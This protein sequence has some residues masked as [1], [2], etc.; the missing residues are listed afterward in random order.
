MSF[1]YGSSRWHFGQRKVS[2][3]IPSKLEAS[4]NMCQRGRS[5]QVGSGTRRSS[6]P[7][8]LNACAPTRAQS[9]L[10][11]CPEDD[12]SRAPLLPGASAA[13]SCHHR[14]E[15]A[16]D[17]RV[18]LHIRSPVPS[19]GAAL[20]GTAGS[21]V[22]ASPLGW[23]RRCTDGS[24]SCRSGICWTK[25]SL[26]PRSHASCTGYPEWGIHLPRSGPSMLTIYLAADASGI[27]RVWGP[28]SC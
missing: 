28:L 6:A 20:L 17:H 12:E 9:S 22:I 4:D 26:E 8:P 13:A 24:L 3:P 5:A 21:R 1:A 15:I 18:K 27:R 14:F 10:R 25:V 11:R 23:R 16:Q 7:E 2:S 19:R